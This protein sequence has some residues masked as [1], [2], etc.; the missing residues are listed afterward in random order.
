MKQALTTG[1]IWLVQWSGAV[2]AGGKSKRFGQDKARFVYG[3]KP[4]LGWV[5]SSL[6]TSPDRFIVSNTDY[7][8]FG[9]P[10]HPDLEAGGDSL[11]GLHSALHHAQHEWVAVAACD[12][13]FLTQEFWDFLLKHTS[14]NIKAVAASSGDYLEPLGAFYHKSLEGEVLKRLQSG[15]LRMQTLLTS[16]PHVAM[17]KS[18]L[19]HR[20]GGNLFVNANRLEDLPTQ[21]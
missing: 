13:P 19:E 3:G 16:I 15:Q 8:D 5:L 7:A 4:L 11:S 1:R 21:N 20:F 12:Q 10:V 14:P 17:D 9:L 2:L 6:E 18:E